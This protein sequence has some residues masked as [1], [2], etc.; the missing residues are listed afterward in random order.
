LGLTPQVSEVHP[1]G[2]VKQNK[3]CAKFRTNHPCLQRGR[4][5]LVPILILFV[6]IY[7]SIKY[8]LRITKPD[9]Y[10]IAIGV[11]LKAGVY[12]DK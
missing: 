8:K 9:A 5:V 7:L 1:F 3:I 2:A 12:L 11:V 4:L 10:L 6:N